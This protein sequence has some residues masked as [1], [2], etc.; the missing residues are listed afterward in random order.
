MQNDILFDNIYIG[1]SVADAEKLQAETYDIKV[2]T[3]EAEREATKPKIEDK[4]KSPLDL[5]FTDDPVRY[6]KDKTEVFIALAKKDPMEAVKAVPEVAGALVALFGIFA[7][8]AFSIVGV[9][10]AAAQAQAQQVKA[11]GKETAKVVK[12]KVSEAAATGSE[13]IQSEVQK[14]TTRSSAAE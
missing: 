12:E 7:A 9:N 2:K 3:E 5:K 11:K 6:I 1:H 14:R 13:K 10:S 4:P 8:V